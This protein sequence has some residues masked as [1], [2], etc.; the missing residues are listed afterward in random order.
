MMCLCI[1]VYLFCCC[2]SFTLLTYAKTSVL[3]EKLTLTCLG[4]KFPAFYITKK[5]ITLFTQAQATDMSYLNPTHAHISCPASQLLVI[6][7]L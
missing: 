5:F 1:F 7:M 6:L 2:N 4:K 3:V